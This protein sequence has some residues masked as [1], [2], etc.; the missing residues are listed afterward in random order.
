MQREQANGLLDLGNESGHCLVW[1]PRTGVESDVIESEA[2]E[3]VIGITGQ[4]VGVHHI[5][6]DVEQVRLVG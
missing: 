1:I 5:I 4:R 3:L 6:D 2:I